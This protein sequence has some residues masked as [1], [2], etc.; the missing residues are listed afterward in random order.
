MATLEDAR[1]A[2]ET[3]KALV[4]ALE[5]V[6]GVGVALVKGAHV[7]KVNLSRELRDSSLV[8]REVD[9]VPVVYQVVGRTTKQD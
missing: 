2:K 1:K 5:E 9:G 3:V 6:R 8:P 7:V 4:A